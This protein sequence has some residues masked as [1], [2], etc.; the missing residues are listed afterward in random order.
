MLC[1][2]IIDGVLCHLSCVWI[3]FHNASIHS[4]F[5][6]LFSANLFYQH[7]SVS[8]F[9]RAFRL[10]PPQPPPPPRPPPFHLSFLDYRDVTSADGSCFSFLSVFAPTLQTEVFV[11]LTFSQSWRIFW[12]FR[13]CT[14]LHSSG[15]VTQI[16]RF[17]PCFTCNRYLIPHLA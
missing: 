4:C 11:S 7:I 1:F 3:L 5:K 2:A 8:Q 6:L 9:L 17:E 15:S 10:P 14:N 13:F 12:G 16:G